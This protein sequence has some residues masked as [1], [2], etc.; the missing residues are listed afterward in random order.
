MGARKGFSL[1]CLLHGTR[2][3]G[4]LGKIQAV[5]QSRKAVLEVQG[6]QLCA[7]GKREAPAELLSHRRLCGT[8]CAAEG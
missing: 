1:L 7:G 8:A 3:L 2:F 5:K 6:Q 4:F